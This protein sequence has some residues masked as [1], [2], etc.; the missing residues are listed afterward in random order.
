MSEGSKISIKFQYIK[1]KWLPVTNKTLRQ[2]ETPFYNISRKYTFDIC[3][4]TAWNLSVYPDSLLHCNI[5]SMQYFL[6]DFK[7]NISMQTSLDSELH[8]GISQAYIVF[9]LNSL[10]W[11]I[12]WTKI[13]FYFAHLF[14]S[15]LPVH[16]VFI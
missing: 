11:T 2:K 12:L 6:R 9:N 8:V 14:Y 15:C 16:K 1:L 7:R 13:I 10:F 5:F 3:I 4:N